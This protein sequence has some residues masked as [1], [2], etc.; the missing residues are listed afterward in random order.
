MT[1]LGIDPVLGYERSSKFNTERR[2]AMKTKT[3]VKAG[4]GG[5]KGN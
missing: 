2:R 4:L 3:N 5:V 1:L